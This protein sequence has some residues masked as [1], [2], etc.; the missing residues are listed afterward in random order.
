[1]KDFLKKDIL[2]TN[3]LAKKLYKEVKDLPI[4]DF[5]CHLDPKEIYEDRVFNNISD[6]WLEFDHYKWRLMRTNGTSENVIKFEIDEE[7]KLKEFFKALDEAVG[8]P[9]YIWA[10]M[11]LR[12]YFNIYTAPKAINYKYI[13]SETFKKMSS[14][15]YTARN[16]IKMRNVDTLITTD[17]PTSDLKYH[18]L[19]KEENLSFKVLPCIRMDNLLNIDNE[20]YFDY[21]KKVEELVGYEIDSYEKLIDATNDRI[22]YFKENGCVSMDISFKDIPYDALKDPSKSFSEIKDGDINED[23]VEC[24]KYHF[25]KDI[26]KLLKENKMV[27]Q[28]HVGVLRNQD[29]KE[30]IKHGRDIGRDSIGDPISVEDLNILLNDIEMSSGLPKTIIYPLNPTNYYSVM[31][32]LLDYS[33][34]IKGKLQLGAAWWFN[35]HEDSIRSVLDVYKN[36]SL[37]GVF[38]GMLTDSRSFTSYARHDYFRR[39]LCS[40][41]SEIVLKGEYPYDYNILVEIV[42]NISYYNSK[43]YFME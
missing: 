14:N 32:S 27:M 43:K 41:I 40:Y 2:L 25:L 38:N 26:A 9:V 11:E 13:Y 1:M 33:K 16:L 30:F 4:F 23:N 29:T 39:I 6:L 3:N 31:S 36:E 21:L 12:K 17:D 28:L 37:L 34:E 19:L 18:K 8:N 10:M 20:N 42:K 7:T 5:H 15:T 35:D 24:F 22:K